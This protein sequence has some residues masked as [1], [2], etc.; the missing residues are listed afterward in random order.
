MYCDPLLGYSLEGSDPLS[1][2]S[3]DKHDE[4][5]CKQGTQAKT[6]MKGEICQEWLRLRTSILIKFTTAEKLSITSSFLQ[7]GEMRQY[8]SCFW[9]SCSKDF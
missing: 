5:V 9:N 2:F 3:T 1:Q 6:I 8:F 4:I 7:G